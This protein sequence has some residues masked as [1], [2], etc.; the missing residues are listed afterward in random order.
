MNNEEDFGQ[1]NCIAENIHGRKEAIVFILSMCL[2]FYICSLSKFFV[3]LEES[4]ILSTLTT[5]KLH[6]HHVKNSSIRLKSSRKHLRLTTT[7][8]A[9][10][11]R[12]IHISSSS[13]HLWTSRR[14]INLLFLLLLLIRFKR[15]D[16]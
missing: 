1:Y 12:D 3:Y 5:K 13:Y 11:E 9:Y 14:L 15:I 10:I 16:R 4:V 7:T 2:L 6:H 8:N